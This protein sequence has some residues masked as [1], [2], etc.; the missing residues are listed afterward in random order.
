MMLAGCTHL[1]L[2]GH[3]EGVTL[4]DGIDPSNP[5]HAGSCDADYHFDWPLGHKLVGEK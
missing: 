5:V 3:C 4:Y 1:E 2:R